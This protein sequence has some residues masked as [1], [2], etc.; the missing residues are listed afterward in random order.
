ML[1][2]DLAKTGRYQVRSDV[3]ATIQADFA[4]G[5][6]TDE[7]VAGA[8]AKVWQQDGYLMD[9]HTA[10]GYSVMQQY[11]A[12]GDAT[13]NV[14]LATASPY[15]FPRAVAK[16]LD[17]PVSGDDFSL[18]AQLQQLSGVAIPAN[19]ARLAAMTPQP[20]HVVAPAA[21]GAAIL[22]AAKEVFDDDSRVRSG[23]NR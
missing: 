17:L 22:D 19:L 6:A 13:P 7:Q 11:R 20:K 14:L 8:I 21:M 3:L 10:V 23:N 16:A 15:K 9:P 12:T 18:M 5:F 2:K 4:G 1:M